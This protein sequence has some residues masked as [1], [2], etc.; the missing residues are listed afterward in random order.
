LIVHARKAWLQGL[1]PRENRDI[2]PLDYA[3]VRRLKR[4]FPATP[5]AING[6][7]ADLATGLSLLAPDGE[8]PALDG[9]M[10]GR[11]A[12]QNPTLLLDVDRLFFDDATPQLDMREAL[13]AFI[14][15]IES[16]V[17]AGHSPHAVTRHLLGAFHNMPGARAFRRHLSTEAVKSGAKAAVLAEAL[18]YLR[19]PRA[20]IAGEA[21]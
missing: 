20:E 15:Y 10:L 16:V 3:L 18:A 11:A 6:G 4:A 21:A 5:V 13:A 7:I 14:P 1:S 2:P 12:Y 19:S 8:L 9:V 17:A